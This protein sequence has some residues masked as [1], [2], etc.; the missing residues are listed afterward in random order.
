MAMIQGKAHWAKIVGKP[1]GGYNKAILEW[2]VDVSVE[3]AAKDALAADGVKT[4]NKGDERGDFITFKRK[5]L[6]KDGSANSNIRIVNKFGQPW[7]KELIGNGSVV[8]VKYLVN[9]STFEG[10]VYKK[11]AVMA[12]QVV[13]HVP[14]EGKGFEDDFPVAEGA[15]EWNEGED[16]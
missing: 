13:E 3:K 6:K 2:T 1:V 15:E 12:V 5:A 8:N 9:E 7:G 11:P 4:K 14:Y 16:E 10:R